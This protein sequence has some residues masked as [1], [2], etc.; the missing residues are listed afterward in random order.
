MSVFQPAVVLMYHRV[1]PTARDTHRL[2]VR[3]DRFAAQMEVLRRSEHVVPLG[4]VRRPSRRRRVSIT[5]DDG[6]ADNALTAR[7]I[8]EDAGLPATFFVTARMI[9]GALSPW[10][11]ELEELVLEG[12]PHDRWLR[13]S[14]DGRE[15]AADVG[16]EAARHRAHLALHRR[17]RRLRREDID[18]AITELR[19]QIT[20]PRAAPDEYRFMTAS[21]LRDVATSRVIEI[22]G[23]ASTHQQLSL[24][25][26]PDQRV[27]IVD[28]RRALQQ[29]TGT[30]VTT[31][32][33]P[34]GGR[35]AFD[36]T[37]ARM[38][39][40]AGYALACAGVAGVV[41][42]RTDRFRVPRVVVGDWDSAE[43][44]GRLDRWFR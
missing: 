17:L 16:S 27:E 23:H 9:D 10:W 24:L 21:Q 7:P 15:F 33:Y 25:P 31:F 35:D 37:S 34:Y 30:D 2:R 13:L 19:D 4:E 42:P 8:L 43:F 6:Y 40:E 5:F 20:L 36:E 26:E 32:A 28:G 18:G 44:A 12:R 38:A 14:L 11:D 3:P 22:G 39:E 41:R 29:L 1:A